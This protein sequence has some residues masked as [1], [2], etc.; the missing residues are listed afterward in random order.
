MIG[1]IVI[2]DRVVLYFCLVAEVLIGSGDLRSCGRVITALDLPSAASLAN[3][4]T[5]SLPFTLL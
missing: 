1:F 4:S 2:F 5:F 3:W